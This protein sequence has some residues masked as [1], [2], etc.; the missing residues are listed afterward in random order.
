METDA[1]THSQTLA[2]AQR[3]LWK[4]EGR[5]EAARGVKD[6]TRTFTRIN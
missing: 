1:E 5:V 2:R 6:T 3:I 4:R